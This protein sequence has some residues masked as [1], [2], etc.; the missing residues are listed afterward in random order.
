MPRQWFPCILYADSE[1]RQAYQ[2]GFSLQCFL[3]FCSQDLEMRQVDR[4]VPFRE[5]GESKAVQAL[6]KD[7]IFFSNRRHVAG[8]KHK[9]I[10]FVPRNNG[11]R[12]WHLT[13]ELFA[14]FPWTS[15]TRNGREKQLNRGFSLSTS[16]IWMAKHQKMSSDAN[17]QNLNII[18]FCLRPLCK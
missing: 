15:C 5:R 4:K 13:S 8:G 9:I 1:M 14:Y 12:R 16:W 17:W 6:Y 3:T 11:A 2:N 10:T 18:C 7:G